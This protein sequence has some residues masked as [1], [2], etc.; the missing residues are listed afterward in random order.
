MLTQTRKNDRKRS[1]R[2]VLDRRQVDYQFGSSEWLQ[3]VQKDYVSWPKSERRQVFR[4]EG[5]RRQHSDNE[6][7]VKNSNDDYTSDL[8][9]KEEIIFFNE[10]FMKKSD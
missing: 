1:E 9:T 5:E 3:H 4:R 6:S 7:V 10:L 2:R 8:L